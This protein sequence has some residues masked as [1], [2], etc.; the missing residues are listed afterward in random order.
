MYIKVPGASGAPLNKQSDAP[1]TSAAREACAATPGV[2][3]ALVTP[4]VTV[5][6]AV[7]AVA[8]AADVSASTADGGRVAAA[9][10]KTAIVRVAVLFSFAF[11][12]FALAVAIGATAVGGGGDTGRWVAL[13]CMGAAVPVGD[14][15]V[16]PGVA[17][18]GATETEED[19]AVAVSEHDWDTVSKRD[20]DTVFVLLRC[21]CG[22]AAGDAL[23][24]QMNAVAARTARG[25]T[26][27][28]A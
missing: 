10:G 14:S 16:G 6:V 22:T 11:C 18:A 23:R 5:A 9:G 1:D 27:V 19:A 3:K 8:T 7:V 25:V 12:G 21:D 26:L 17:M 2:T 13:G 24:R 15:V 4:A 20:W 28:L